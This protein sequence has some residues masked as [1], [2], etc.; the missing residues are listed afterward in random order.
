M[1]SLIA[2]DS[3]SSPPMKICN[4]CSSLLIFV[5]NSSSISFEIMSFKN[6]GAKIIESNNL[7]SSSSNAFRFFSFTEIS[8][9]LLCR[10]FM[11]LLIPFS[12]SLYSNKLD[13]NLLKISSDSS[14]FLNISMNSLS[15]VAKFEII[16]VS[17]LLKS[18]YT[19]LLYCSKFMFVFCSLLSLSNNT[20]FSFFEISGKSY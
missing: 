20:N 14:K 10:I 8:D 9:D 19:F 4:F 18:L 11:S 5:T 16:S 12:L 1:I 15:C 7:K 13:S 2:V 17:N 6:S 3:G